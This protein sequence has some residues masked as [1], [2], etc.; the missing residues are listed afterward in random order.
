MQVPTDGR[1]I[2]PCATTAFTLPVVL[3]LRGSPIDIRATTEGAVLLV[4]PVNSNLP[5][6][7]SRC[8][9]WLNPFAAVEIAPVKGGHVLIRIIGIA[10]RAIGQLIYTALMIRC[11]R[12]VLP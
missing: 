4:A 8:I 3:T 6:F 9:I 10:E 5:G 2:F 12:K 7:T 1:R 11:R